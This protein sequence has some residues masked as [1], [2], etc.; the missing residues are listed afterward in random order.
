[1]RFQYDNQS[2]LSRLPPASCWVFKKITKEGGRDRR[3][4][5]CEQW[6][7]HAESVRFVVHYPEVKSFA[8]EALYWATFATLLH[9]DLILKSLYFLY[10]R[11][12]VSINEKNTGSEI[13][14]HLSA[15]L[16]CHALKVESKGFSSCQSF[17]KT[18]CQFSPKWC[19]PHFGTKPL[20]MLFPPYP[21]Q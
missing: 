21:L 19:M 20:Y 11:K 6:T 16:T 2:P 14:M 1:M 9:S 17:C 12:Y 4:N 13:V 15:S 8:Y 18:R 7:P 5:I 10:F 3:N